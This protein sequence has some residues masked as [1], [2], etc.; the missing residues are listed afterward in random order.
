MMAPNYLHSNGSWVGSGIFVEKMSHSGE[1]SNIHSVCNGS[2][3]VPVTN[4]VIWVGYG[5]VWSFVGTD[6]LR[7]SDRASNPY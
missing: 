7:W 1:F 4:S 5:A 3:S 6:E 2:S